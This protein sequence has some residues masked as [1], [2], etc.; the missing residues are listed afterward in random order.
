MKK[1]KILFFTIFI[2]GLSQ[3]QQ[4]RGIKIKQN[5]ENDTIPKIVHS[6]ILNYSTIV[7]LDNN[8]ASLE[9]LDLLN[10]NSIK[11]IKIEKGSFEINDKKYT[12]KIIIE[13]KPYL[14]TTF[15]TID[16]LITKYI[17]L[18]KKQNYIC[19]IDGEI[20]NADKNNTF[21]DEKNIL[22]IKEVKLDKIESPSNLTLIKILTKN[23]KQS[24]NK[25]GIIIRGNEL[26]LTN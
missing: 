20:I 9:T 21:L 8:Y 11:S 14:N 13:T 16:Q 10:P 17:K 26:S 2:Y 25:G 4:N 23:K 19:S 7:L 5:I 6:Q 18:Q 15:V 24:N 3:A 1:I 12:G 22:K